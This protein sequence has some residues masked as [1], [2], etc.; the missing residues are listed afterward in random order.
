[1]HQPDARESFARVLNGPLHPARRLLLKRCVVQGVPGLHE[2]ARTSISWGLH[3]HDEAVD[4]RLTVGR[5][6]SAISAILGRWARASY[7]LA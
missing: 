5:A 3:L 2:T 6:I 7:A 4:G 1:M